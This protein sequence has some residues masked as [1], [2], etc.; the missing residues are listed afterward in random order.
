MTS[1]VFMVASFIVTG[2]G[3]VKS[4]GSVVY[5]RS[6]AHTPIAYCVESLNL[7]AGLAGKRK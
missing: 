2:L 4:N 6:Q 5:P 3:Y 7:A 1:V